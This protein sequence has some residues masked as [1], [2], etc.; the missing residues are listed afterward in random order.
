MIKNKKKQNEYLFT[1]FI[2]F[3]VRLYCRLEY[4]FRMFSII[5]MNALNFVCQK[6]LC[7]M[8]RCDTSCY[9]YF[10]P[11]IS[12]RES[13][14]RFGFCIKPKPDVENRKPQP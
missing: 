7:R 4:L 12:T 13:M 11:F 14:V 10:C 9:P 8:Y 2:C 3:P 6:K 1:S 5:L